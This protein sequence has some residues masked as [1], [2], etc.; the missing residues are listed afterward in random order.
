MY[1]L[2]ISETDLVR[3]YGEFTI[4]N[5][6]YVDD[7]AKSS[8]PKYKNMSADVIEIVSVTYNIIK[9]VKHFK[10]SQ[11]SKIHRLLAWDTLSVQVFYNF[12]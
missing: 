4:T 12:K 5:R 10:M 11:T 3:R 6:D 8:S 7:L 2:I 9:K 1:F